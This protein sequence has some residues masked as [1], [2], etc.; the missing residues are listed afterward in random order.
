M[1][2]Q[3]DDRLIVA[4][5]FAAKRHATD[6][7]GKLAG[8]AGFYKL[9]LGSLAWGGLELAFELKNDGM[10]VF[11]D[12]KLFDIASVV[13]RA[14]ERLSALD[15]DFLTV[16][17]DPYVV[18]SAVQGRG[19]AT[20]KI[21]AVTFLTSVD[22]RDLD[23]ALVRDGAIGD[24]AKERAV[25]AFDAGA[26]GIIASA[27]E[28]ESIRAIPSATGK[29]VVTPGIRLD[30]GAGNDQKRIMT[31]GAAINAGVD[32]IVVGRPIIE[33]KNPVDAAKKILAGL[34]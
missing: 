28:A 24:L 27:H 34:P 30:G 12:L 18:R 17:G 7:V 29:L 2:G 8:I 6:M 15:V 22:R 23:A 5:D 26:D 32:H 4:L 11:L 13:A 20:T 31:P 3:T 19:D 9:G 16:H 25:R 1:I 33:A 14:A 10:R 21:L